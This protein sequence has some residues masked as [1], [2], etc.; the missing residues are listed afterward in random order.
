MKNKVRLII[1]I[2]FI[3]TGFFLPLF[4]ESSIAASTPAILSIV[5]KTYQF[6]GIEVRGGITIYYY[7]FSIIM[8]NTG[9]TT[10]EN[11]TLSIK[12]DEGFPGLQHYTFLPGAY[13]EFTWSR[14]MF[15]SGGNHQINISYYPTDDAIIRDGN[16]SGSSFLI[17]PSNSDT[18]KKS[19]PGFEIILLIGAVVF[20]LLVR[21]KI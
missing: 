15:T 1:I 12:D 5:D 4:V 19:T 7:N 14:W 18:T 10:S 3:S 13:K 17:L 21:R 2:C 11:T 20:L 6:A 8:R 16:N 9:D